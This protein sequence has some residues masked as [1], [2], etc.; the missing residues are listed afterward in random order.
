MLPASPDPAAIAQVRYENALAHALALQ[1]AP[2][3]GVEPSGTLRENAMEAIAAIK[4]TN[5][6]DVVVELDAGILSGGGSAF[7]WR[8]GQ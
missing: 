7:D 3:F 1:W 5:A 6:P 2:M 4:R 8:T